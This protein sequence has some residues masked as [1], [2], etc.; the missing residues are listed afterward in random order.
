MACQR[1]GHKQLK[2]VTLH[3]VVQVN[4]NTFL[5]DRDG[6]VASKTGQLKAAE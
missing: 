5:P 6:S 2:R 4:I 1:L 3:I